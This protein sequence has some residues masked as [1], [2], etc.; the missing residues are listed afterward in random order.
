M[1]FP[2]PRL[3]KQFQSVAV[4]CHFRQPAMELTAADVHALALRRR[5]AAAA[6]AAAAAAKAAQPRAM[7]QPTLQAAFARQRGDTGAAASQTAVFPLPPERA[8]PASSFQSP[9]KKSGQADADVLDLCTPSPAASRVLV[10]PPQ[11]ASKGYGSRGGRPAR[12]DGGAGSRTDL[13]AQQKVD[14]CS[15]LQT[16][17]TKQGI[18]KKAAWRQFSLSWKLHP[19]TV[20]RIWT[21]R[22][23]WQNLIKGLT[24]EGR[25]RPGVRTGRRNGRPA[26]RGRQR[27]VRR[28]QPGKRG[29]LGTTDHL[30]AERQALK[31][32]ALDQEAIGH[33]LSG[34]DL[35]FSFEVMVTQTVADLVRK[36]EAG[37]ILSAADSARLAFAQQRLESWSR[38]GRQLQKARLR[39]QTQIGFRERVTSRQTVYSQAEEQHRLE[40]AWRSFDR[41]V[42]LLSQ[43]NADR[44]AHVAQNPWQVMSRRAE[45]V[46]CFTDQIPVWLKVKAGSLLISDE[47]LATQ[48]IEQRARQ[49][50]QRR[51]QQRQQQDTAE[52]QTADQSRLISGP[53]KSGD[54]RWRVTL[55]ARQEVHDYFS[56]GRQP[57]GLCLL[58]ILHPAR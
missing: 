53:G 3:L 13:T 57:S 27:T 41:A 50:Q 42:W 28:R 2:Q 52:E 29:Y 21:G 45:T 34:A 55:I 15:E 24:E 58:I 10:T 7:K 36:R 20:Q 23:I 1:S 22:E 12:V 32:W 16:A 11:S 46:I 38:G 49:R 17:F 14:L 18:S 8:L 4:Y 47:M 43:T 6:D 5:Q 56:P 48:R 40:T 25:G 31:Q 39:L 9:V 54:A 30:R 44:L 37:E 33:R 19:R 35:F 26:K 51:P